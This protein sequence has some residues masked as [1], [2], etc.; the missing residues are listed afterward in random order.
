MTN[1][2]IRNQRSNQPFRPQHRLYP[3]ELE[4]RGRTIKNRCIPKNF[5]E[6][7]IPPHPSNLSPISTLSGGP[8]GFFLS[9]A[10]CE[11][12]QWMTVQPK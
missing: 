1:P 10:A 6:S 8:L 5:S 9:A 4:L 12:P 7:T 3:I 2:G 11:T